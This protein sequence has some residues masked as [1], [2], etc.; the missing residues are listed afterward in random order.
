MNKDIQ[1]IINKYKP[2]ISLSLDLFNV[3]VN[4]V[5]NNIIFYIGGKTLTCHPISCSADN[6]NEYELDGY[7]NVR[8]LF[9]TFSIDCHTNCQINHNDIIIHKCRSNIYSIDEFM[10][11]NG[12]YIEYDLGFTYGCNIYDTISIKKYCQ[13]IKDCIV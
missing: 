12:F 9:T 11:I 7:I 5:D 4:R 10:K 8:N 3:I 6:L 13:F 1:Y 2:R